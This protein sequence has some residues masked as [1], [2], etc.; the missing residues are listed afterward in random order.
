M[1]L[2]LAQHCSMRLPSYYRVLLC[3]HRCF[4][5]ITTSPAMLFLTSSPHSL[6]FFITLICT[7]SRMNALCTNHRRN[8]TE[9]KE[10]VPFLLINK[11]NRNKR[12]GR[13]KLL[14]RA[15]AHIIEEPRLSD[16]RFIYFM[17]IF[18]FLVFYLPSFISLHCIP[19]CACLWKLQ[20]SS[21]DFTSSNS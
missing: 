8:I 4:A 6:S 16:L 7:I 15:C 17:F 13:E 12:R 1:P 19:F 10:K 14:M 18:I 2:T 20:S 3:S 9:W 5:L 11:I 21:M